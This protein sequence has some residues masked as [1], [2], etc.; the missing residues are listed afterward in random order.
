[1]EQLRDNASVSSLA[2]EFTILTA[3]RTGET[4][5]ARWSEIDWDKGNWTIPA[6][7]MKAGQTHRVPLSRPSRS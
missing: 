5:G 1:M 4:L 3:V 6:E 2:L 7:R